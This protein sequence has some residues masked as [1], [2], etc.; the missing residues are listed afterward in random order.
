[1]STTP[2]QVHRMLS[3]PRYVQRI[4]VKRRRCTMEDGFASY[5]ETDDTIYGSVQPAPGETLKV[6]PEGTKLDDVI[7]IYTAKDLR[8]QATT[9]DSGT[10]YGDVVLDSGRRYECVMC[11]SW[12]RYGYV[13]AI[14]VAEALSA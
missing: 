7:V 2:F 9:D 10:G 12:R 8:S 3:N 13:K 6:L 5:A 1:M 4:E 11:E 14:C